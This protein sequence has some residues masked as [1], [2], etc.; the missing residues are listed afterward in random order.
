MDVEMQDGLIAVINKHKVSAL[1]GLTLEVLL[2][3]HAPP[4]RGLHG[5]QLVRLL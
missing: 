2:L 5:P 4:G 3:L 1:V